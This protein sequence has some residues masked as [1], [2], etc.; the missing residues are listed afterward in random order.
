MTRLSEEVHSAGVRRPHSRLTCIYTL[1]IYLFI[2]IY[3]DRCFVYTK[4]NIVTNT[5]LYVSQCFTISSISPS[6]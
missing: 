3:R 6:L 4:N 5:I 2:F 1:F